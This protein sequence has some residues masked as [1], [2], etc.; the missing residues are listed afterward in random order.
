MIIVL[1]SCGLSPIMVKLKTLKLV[2]D[3][4]ARSIQY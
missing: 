2:F 3:A 4:S 1:D